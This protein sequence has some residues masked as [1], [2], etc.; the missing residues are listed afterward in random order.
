MELYPKLILDALST[1][2][3]PGTGKNIVE[4]K[5]VDDD[6]RIAGLSVSFTLIFDKPTDPFMK[7]TVKAAEAAMAAEIGLQGIESE[8]DIIHVAA[9][10]GNDD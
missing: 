3:Y 6:M 7:S 10:I 5:M 8:G 2:R 4:M 1:V 9:G